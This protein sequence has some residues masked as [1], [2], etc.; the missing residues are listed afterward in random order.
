[1]VITDDIFFEKSIDD[2]FIAA[3]NGHV[4]SK[5]LGHGWAISA[6]AMIK[7]AYFDHF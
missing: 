6:R 1:M 5:S 2:Q 7:K 3:G 4:A